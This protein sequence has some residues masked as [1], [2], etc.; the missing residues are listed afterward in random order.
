MKKAWTLSYPFSAQ[1]RLWSD[2]VGAHADLSPRWV[3]SHSVGFVSRWLNREG[4]KVSNL[5]FEVH[6]ISGSSSFFS[7]LVFQFRVFVGIRNS[8]S[9]SPATLEQ[10]VMKEL[11]SYWTKRIDRNDQFYNPEFMSTGEMIL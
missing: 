6:L 4:G 10:D 5:V 11:E 7:G 2:W 3:H 1:R 8:R 9:S